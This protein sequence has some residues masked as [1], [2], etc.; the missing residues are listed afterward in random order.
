SYS[1]LSYNRVTVL[2]LFQSVKERYLIMQRTSKTSAQTRAC[3]DCGIGSRAQRP[4]FRKLGSLVSGNGATNR[5]KFNRIR[6]R[7]DAMGIRWDVSGKGLSVHYS[8]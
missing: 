3:F 5:S 8:L 7:V 6:P 4:P 1:Q 2:V